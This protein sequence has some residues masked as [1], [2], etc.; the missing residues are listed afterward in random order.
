M[1]KA[2]TCPICGDT[3]NPISARQKYCNKAV[4]RECVIC[5]KEYESTCNP[6]YSKCCSKECT[7][8]YTHK[9]SVASYKSITKKCVLCG[10][11]FNPR[12]NT[13]VVCTDK[14]FRN[15]AICGKQ[16][17]IYKAKNHDISQL[18][19]TCSKECSIKYRFRNGNP[20][21]N[22]ESREKA[23]ATMQER[24]GADHPMHSDEVKAK[25]DN[26]M[27]ERYGVRR[28]T[29]TEEYV[30]KA[31]ATMQERYG[32]DWA[33]QSTEYLKK[34]QDTLFE[35]YGVTNAMQS[36]E[37]KAKVVENYRNKTSYD[38][39]MQNPEVKE[40]I[41]E[42][43]KKRFGVDWAIQS[44]T[45]RAKTHDS[46]ISKYG[47]PY[48]MQSSVLRK[49]IEHTN[50]ER[51]GFKNAA[52][53]PKVQAKISSTMLEKYGH[54]RYSQTDSWHLAVMMDP[55][56][57]EYFN[58]FKQDPI[59]FI[60]KYFS[61]KP[62]LE[63]L[64]KSTGVGNEA[65][66][67]VLDKFDCRSEVAFNYSTME[68]EVQRELLAIDPSLKIVCNT[69]KIIPPYE[70]DLYL[71]DYKIGI[72]CNPT[73]THNSSIGFLDTKCEPT[74][75]QYHKMKSDLA[76]QQGIFLFHL[77]GYEWKYKRD[78]MISMLRNLLG[79]NETKI[80]ARNTVVREVDNVTAVQFLNSNH[81]QGRVFS[82]VRLGLFT[83]DTNELVSVMTF[84]KLRKTMGTNKGADENIWELTRF[85]NKLN[86]SVVGGASK[87]FKH[88]I[89]NYT[90]EEIRSFSDRAHTRG[91]L[92]STLGFTEM[93]RSDASYAWIDLKTDRAFHRIYAQKRNIKRFLKD[94]NIDLNQTEFQIMESH[95]YV[96]LFDS[97]TITWQWLRS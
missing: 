12:N 49:Q 62:T 82:S 37:V 74:P 72:E 22:P 87:L 84:G 92:Y 6:T 34:A 63:E 48:V 31:K 8:K 66:A 41:K 90:P 45:V 18:S 40:K 81:R 77:F 47:V 67:A 53:N 56:R 2:K 10:K 89:K 27:M 86:T 32:V 13:Q 55:T 36:D 71:P 43:N 4:T 83:K 93:R 64:Y 79:A 91:N 26:T 73:A 16:F 20:F 29:Q 50:E 85:C 15:C 23:K 3:F 78:I 7:D 58:E 54:K 38:Y 65:I 24:Y 80:Y 59:A 57:L 69:H 11:D 25:L 44:E 51:Y 95:G 76:E 60:H 97:G 5:G 52:Q 68:K 19:Q 1:Y 17:E 35:H 33:I 21:T 94:D 42:T 30:E 96:S 61:D 28:Y 75:K 46:M 88:F 39:P 9:Q 70:I 14:H